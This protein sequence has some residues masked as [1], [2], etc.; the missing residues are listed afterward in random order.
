[1]GVEDGTL[2]QGGIHVHCDRKDFKRPVWPDG[3]KS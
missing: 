1:M 3:V 2:K